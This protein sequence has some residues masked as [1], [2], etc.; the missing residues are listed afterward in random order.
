MLHS[1]SEPP[2]H[3][4]KICMRGLALS[5]P[6]YKDF[7]GVREGSLASTLLW[8]AW[9]ANKLPGRRHRTSSARILQW[10]HGA[11]EYFVAGERTV[12]KQ[13]L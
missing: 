10:G 5:S 2:P 11:F 7:L 12:V 4:I 9:E 1:F 6:L 13:A 8:L 3:N